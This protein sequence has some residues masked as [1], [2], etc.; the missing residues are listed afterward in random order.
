MRAVKNLNPNPIAGAMQVATM[1]LGS[2][3]MSQFKLPSFN[4]PAAVEKYFSEEV[5]AARKLAKWNKM[6]PARQR[7]M[8]AASVRYQPHL[9]QDIMPAYLK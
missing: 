6:T 8:I 5:V 2:L 9:V 1:G 4:L 3:K 7:E